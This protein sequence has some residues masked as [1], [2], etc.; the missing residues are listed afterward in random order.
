VLS[1]VAPPGLASDLEAFFEDSSRSEVFRRELGSR[2]DE[3]PEDLR[4][5]VGDAGPAK[6][7]TAETARDQ[8]LEQMM[9]TDPRLRDAV[10][11]LDLKLKE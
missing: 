4:F 7:L 1:L 9:D 2:I 10:Q 5:E 8:K 6:R 3:R 11:T